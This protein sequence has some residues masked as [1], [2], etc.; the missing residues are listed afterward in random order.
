MQPLAYGIKDFAGLVG[1]GQT[2]IFKMIKNGEL[3]AIKI[4]GRTLIPATEVARLIMGGQ[5]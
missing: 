1:I 2:T 4:R 5:S 3:R